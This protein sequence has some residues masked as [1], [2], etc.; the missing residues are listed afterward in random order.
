[1]ITRQEIRN[2]VDR[3]MVSYKICLEIEWSGIPSQPSIYHAED[4]EGKKVYLNQLSPRLPMNEMKI[5][6]EGF[7]EGLHMIMESYKNLDGMKKK[8]TQSIIDKIINIVKNA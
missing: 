8:Q 2:K 3:L 6:L 1:M 7:E 5:W 4:L